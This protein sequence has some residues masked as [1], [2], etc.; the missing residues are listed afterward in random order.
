MARRILF[1]CFGN[2]CRSPMAAALAAKLLPDVEAESVGVGAYPMMPA[3]KE[4]VDVM[5]EYGLD[6]TG[7]RSREVREVRPE[8][9]DLVVTLDA[10]VAR[11]LRSQVQ[12]PPDRLV[13]WTV[14]DPI[15]GPLEA[16]RG[17]AKK[18]EALIPTLALES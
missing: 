3:A 6:I 11:R 8:E 5:R 15:N 7:H 17:T 1:V 14:D 13:E 2:T 4:A 16:Y 10:F 18:L 12:V 9:F